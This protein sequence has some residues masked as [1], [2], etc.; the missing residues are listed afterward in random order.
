MTAKDQ[1]LAYA[2]T[3]NTRAFAKRT[4]AEFCGQMIVEGVVIARTPGSKTIARAARQGQELVITETTGAEINEIVA[5][6][7]VSKPVITTSEVARI[8][9]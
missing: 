6:K 9:I 2:K 5:G 3:H 1:L 4:D 7:L 8:T